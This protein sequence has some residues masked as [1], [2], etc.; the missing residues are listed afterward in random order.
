MVGHIHQPMNIVKIGVTIQP[1]I[2]VKRKVLPILPPALI[3][4][5][6]FFFVLC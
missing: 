6:F 5:I 4:E 3:G 1:E 2:F